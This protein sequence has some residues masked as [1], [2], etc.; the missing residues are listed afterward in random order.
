MQISDV[1]LELFRYIDNLEKNKLLQI[2]HY[3]IE[4]KAK[5]VEADFWDS[6][7]EWQ[8]NDIEAGLSDLENGKKRS[9]DKVLAKYE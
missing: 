5:N 6:L 7:N 1:K 4:K 9:I 2:Y 3:L 8:K